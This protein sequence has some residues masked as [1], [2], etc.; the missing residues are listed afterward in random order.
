VPRAKLTTALVA[1]VALTASPPAARAEG[2]DAERMAQAISLYNQAVAQMRAKDWA[3]ACPKL[4]A[5]VRLDPTGVGGKLKLAECYEGA[6]K[7]ASAWA[8]YEVTERAAAQAKQPGRQKRA[9]DRLETLRTQLAQL[10][11]LVP[12]AVGELP[13]LEIRRDGVPL[14]S[15]AW[16]APLP[17]DQGPHV[18]AATATGKERWETTVEAHDGAPISVEVHLLEDTPPPPPPPPV[19]PPLPPVAA[20]PPPPPPAVERF[21]SSQRKASVVVGGVGVAGFTAGMVY[22]VLTIVRRDQSNDGHCFGNLC[23]PAGI[24][25]RQE[26]IGFAHTST[27]LSVAG[28]L[29]VAGGVVLFATAPRVRAVA[30]P[31]GLA[32]VTTW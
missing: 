8:A 30:G 11:V 17:V 23:D 20:P 14:V 18:I 27:A 2:V 21:W 3:G 31:R 5:A 22:G 25:L 12:P 10:T 29:V 28:G 15:A 32:L 16:G 6:G 19:A 4:D 13:G 24:Q 1:L 7:L 9:R 26:G